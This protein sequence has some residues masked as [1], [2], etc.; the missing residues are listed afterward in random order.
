MIYIY[1]TPTFNDVNNILEILFEYEDFVDRGKSPR[2][3]CEYFKN[4]IINYA[5]NSIV[6]YKNIDYN[7]IKLKDNCICGV[8]SCAGVISLTTTIPRVWL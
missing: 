5:Y 6:K 2:Y 7:T 4:Y 8:D 3:L 1:L